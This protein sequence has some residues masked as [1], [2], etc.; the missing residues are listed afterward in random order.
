MKS[1]NKLIRGTCSLCLIQLLIEGHGVL[2][3]DNKANSNHGT[4]YQSQIE[5]LRRV[6]AITGK[7]VP[8]VHQNVKTHNLVQKLFNEQT[9]YLLCWEALKAVG[10][11]MEKP[12]EYFSV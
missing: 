11:T 9:Q 2:V 1:V 7:I 6:E 8:Y 12:L 5:C 10:E 3:T 4:T